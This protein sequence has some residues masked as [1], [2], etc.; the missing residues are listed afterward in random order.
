MGLSSRRIE[1]LFWATLM[2]LWR[3]HRLQELQFAVAVDAVVFASSVFSLAG[4]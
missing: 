1:I 4:A 3:L 2:T